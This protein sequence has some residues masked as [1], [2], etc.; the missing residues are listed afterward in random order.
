MF[1]S[2]VDPY[3]I[4]SLQPLPTC[5]SESQP[6]K[7]PKIKAGEYIEARLKETYAASKPIEAA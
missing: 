3:Q 4:H 5:V 1:D 2:H 6:A 7:Y